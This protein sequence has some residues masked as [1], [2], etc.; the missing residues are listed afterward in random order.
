MTPNINQILRAN[1]RNSTYG[2]PMGAANFTDATTPLYLQ[3]VRFSDGCYAPDHTYWGSPADLWCAFNGDDDP[4]YGAG[5][6]TRI[7]VRAK[8][9]ES[10]KQAVLEDYDVKFRR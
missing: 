8:D 6:G 10:A 9:R 4:E 1:P 2:C 3:R 5:H 7:Y